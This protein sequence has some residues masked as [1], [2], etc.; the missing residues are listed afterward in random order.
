MGQKYSID[1]L[2][3]AEDILSKMVYPI[4]IYSLG[5]TSGDRDLVIV[6][7]KNGSD[8]TYEMLKTGLAKYSPLQEEEL[9]GRSGI[10]RDIYNQTESL[11]KV[12]SQET[13]QDATKKTIGG[14]E[15]QT[16][17]DIQSY[18]NKVAIALGDN[19]GDY[20]LSQRS[21]AHYR[22]WETEM[23]IVTG[24]QICLS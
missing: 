8:F 5:D 16:T 18:E 20:T 24:K 13:S 4:K 9:K 22:D 17:F 11:L 2:L 19:S 7:D 10:Y 1:A 14:S 12:D 15:A 6:V 3:A 23:F 21:D